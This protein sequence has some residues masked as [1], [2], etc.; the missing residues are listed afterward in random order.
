MSGLPKLITG[1]S[2]RL[3][4]MSNPIIPKRKKITP[5]R[6][7]WDGGLFFFSITTSLYSQYLNQVK[8]SICAN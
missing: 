5:T 8:D 2:N 6:V 4:K 1:P 7:I 3:A